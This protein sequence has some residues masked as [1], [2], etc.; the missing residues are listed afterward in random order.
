MNLIHLASKV[1]WGLI[2]SEEAYS[3]W[4]NKAVR[5]FSNLTGLH[6]WPIFEV[7]LHQSMLCSTEMHKTIMCVIVLLGCNSSELQVT[8]RH[9]GGLSVDTTA[10]AFSERG[11]FSSSSGLYCTA[12]LPA[13]V[14]P[15]IVLFACV[16]FQTDIWAGEEG[17]VYSASSK[18]LAMPKSAK[19]E[20]GRGGI[21]GRNDNWPLIIM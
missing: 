5:C 7:C 13:V 19:G 18:S 1:C 17:S 6:Y 14:M 12:L 21:K 20:V 10:A 4:L 2:T 3:P 15:L 16:L 8:K 11:L 9:W